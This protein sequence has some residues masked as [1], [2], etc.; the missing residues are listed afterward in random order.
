M[1]EL[2]SA[3]TSDA[4]PT[5]SRTPMCGTALW[6]CPG[7]H[8]RGTSEAARLAEYGPANATLVVCGDDPDWHKGRMPLGSRVVTPRVA[9]AVVMGSSSSLALEE[10]VDSLTGRERQTLTWLAQGFTHAQIA[11]RMSIS[12]ATV[13]T[14]VKR[15]RRKLRAGNKAQLT[16][17]AIEMGLV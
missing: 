8:P 3:A 7:R 13:D 15:L 17:R 4:W 2:S 10:D 9:A 1:I 12:V 5:A 16:I 11:R 6:I 14:H